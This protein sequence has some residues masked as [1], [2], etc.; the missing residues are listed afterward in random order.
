VAGVLFAALLWARRDTV[1]AQRAEPKKI[2]L[3]SATIESGVVAVGT[4]R[5]TSARTQWE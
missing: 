3:V 5:R 2:G 4:G 1:P